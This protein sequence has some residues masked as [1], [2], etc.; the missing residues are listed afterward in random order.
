[1]ELQ[2]PRAQDPLK[3]GACQDHDV[4]DVSLSRI[5]TGTWFALELKTSLITVLVLSCFATR[6]SLVHNNS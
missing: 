2:N 3:V 5:V 4:I 1:M 6:Q